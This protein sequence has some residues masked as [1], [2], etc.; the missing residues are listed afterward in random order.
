MNKQTPNFLKEIRSINDL[1]KSENI[2]ELIACGIIA[3]KMSGVIQKNPSLELSANLQDSIV[4][5]IIF[6]IFI[7]LFLFIYI[8]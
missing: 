8:S 6:V 5:N 3:E 7:N 2:K 4:S 1:Q